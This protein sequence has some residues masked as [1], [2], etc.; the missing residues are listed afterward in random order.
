MAMFAPQAQPSGN[1]LAEFRA[2]KMTYDGRMVTPD[3][4]KGKLVLLNGEDSLM[5]LQWWDRTKTPMNMEDDLIVINDA[6]FERIP[7]CTTG[8][9]YLLR[10]TSSDKKMF[11]WMQEPK[12]ENDKDLIN[13]AN[14]AIGATIPDKPAGAGAPAAAGGAPSNDLMQMMQNFQQGQ[15]GGPGNAELANILGQFLQQS[16]TGAGGASRTPPVPLQ[17]FMSA[18]VLNQLMDDPEAVAELLGN[19]PEG[20]GT[21]Q[22]LR[23]VFASPQLSQNM[24]IL[25]QAIYSDQLGILFQM[26]GLDPSVLTPGTEPMEALC[27]A[28][29]KKYGPGGSA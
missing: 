19:M 1:V 13:K 7:K 2:G 3:V 16:G 23:E 9:V 20:Q 5:H 25:S 26:L 12:E 15:Q 11:F 24:S 18:E 27:K 29:E 10:F 22:D 4:R 28:M 17:T 14:E 8:R 21:P 6:Y